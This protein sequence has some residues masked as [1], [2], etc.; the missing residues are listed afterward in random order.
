M[1]RKRTVFRRK[2][3][4]IPKELFKSGANRQDSEITRKLKKTTIT[5][6]RDVEVTALKVE[7]GFK[8]HDELPPLVEKPNKY[9]GMKK[10]KGC[11]EYKPLS[12]FTPDPRNVDGKQGRCKACR[13]EKE[14][15]R[16]EQKW[17]RG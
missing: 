2:W 15:E 3:K 11:G 16:Y 17:R 10:C 13:A 7:A 6:P 9:E 4:T 8:S 14:R 1:P 12:K 5:K